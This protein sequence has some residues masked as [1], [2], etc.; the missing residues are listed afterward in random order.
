LLNQREGIAIFLTT[1]YMEEADV[2]CRRIG[3]IDQGKLL[4]V[5][6]PEDLKNLVGKDIVTMQLSSVSKMQRLIDDVDWVSEARVHDGQL[7]LEVT[8]GAE[9]IPYLV[10]LAHRNNLEV[11]LVNLRRP[12]L[13]DVFLYFTGR[14]M[15]E[16]EASGRERMSSRI[17]SWRKR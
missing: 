13:E 10:Q 3:I 17:R 4:V 1:H 11:D 2:L 8:K 15:R 7:H 14:S 6:S 9:R 12:T 5:K 16:E